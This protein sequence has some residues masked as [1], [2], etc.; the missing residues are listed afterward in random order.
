MSI[1]LESPDCP[2]CGADSVWKTSLTGLRDW[3]WRKPGEFQL[4]R[5][6]GCGLV[7]TRPRPTPEALGFYYEESYSGEG[8]AGEG[9]KRFQTD[10]WLGRLI[11]RY[12]LSVLAKVQRLSPE[13][14]LL[15]VGC[16]YGGFLRAAREQSGCA[17][18][19]VDLD[20]G[21]IQQAVDPE[22]CDYRQGELAA[23]GFA[24]E[25][26][27]VVSFME[28]L[29]HHP[30]PVAALK[31]ASK[32][33]KGGGLCVVEV[34]NYG[35]FW[36]R[37]FRGSWLPLLVPQH[38]FHFD[39]KSLRACMEAAGLK[40]LHQQTM[41]YPLEGI[42][43][44]GIALGRLFRVPPYGTPPSWRTP[45][46]V[47]LFLLLFGLYFLWEIPSQALL[48]VLGLAGHQLAIGRKLGK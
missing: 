5:C 31:E 36:R 13:D 34:P 2:L 28:S 29:E 17:I 24:S 22:L 7:A 25:S 27:T 38:L 11:S 14:H 45:F 46:D 10:S 47:A 4:Q 6:T 23:A 32:L 40:V 37:I 26:F 19:G 33:L 20:A 18:S 12:R 16:S 42:A 1:P 9:I 41:F 48:R 39:L 15:D 44:L 21:S 8:E 30:E 3:V 43:S 35:G